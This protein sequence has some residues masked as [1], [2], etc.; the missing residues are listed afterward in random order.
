LPLPAPPSTISG[1]GIRD[2]RVLDHGAAQEA[3][4]LVRVLLD[5][6]EHPRIGRVVVA[7]D[8]EQ[9]AGGV[10]E[11]RPVELAVAEVGQLLDVGRAEVVALDGGANLVVRRPD[12]GAG[13]GGLFE[14]LYRFEFRRQWHTRAFGRSLPAR[15]T[16]WCTTG[17]RLTRKK[18]RLTRQRSRQVYSINNAPRRWPRGTAL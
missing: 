7:D 1:N 2:L 3:R 13:E 8:R 10:V 15:A 4:L 16:P 6:F 11:P 12:S 14:N 18:I 5:H 9:P 17:R